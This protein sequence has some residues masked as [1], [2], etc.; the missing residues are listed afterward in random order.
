MRVFDCK[1]RILTGR[2][3]IGRIRELG[4]SRPMI[5]TDPFFSQ[6]GTVQRI[7]RDMGVKQGEIFD[8]VVPDPGLELVAQGVAVAGKFRPDGI[9]ALGGGSAMDCA[10]GVRYFLE[11]RIPLIAIPTTSGSGSEVT[12]FAILTH[13]GVK[14]PLVDE[15]LR[16]EFA[17]LDEELLAAL[18]PSLVADGGFDV[19]THALEAWTGKNANAFTDALAQSAF[20]TVFHSL[21]ASF[22]GDLTVRLSVHE[23]ACMAGL[24][25]TKAGLGLCHALSHALGGQF[26]VPHGRLNAILLPAVIDS[27]ARQD[28]K[29]YGELARRIGLGGISD[30]VALR[31]LKNGLIRLRTAVSLPENLAQGGIPPAALREK[32]DSVIAAALADPCCETN[33]VPVTQETL[34]Q[35][36]YEVMGRG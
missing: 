29:R 26:H 2:G 12:D 31:N 15:S 9:V 36:L 4:F 24:A 8:K 17:I 18:P 7:I 21:T 23:S 20:A 32:M 33:P 28:P 27:N 6:N 19:L 34:R 11:E 25:F 14:H 1:T 16:P 3:T 13:K 22:R 10:K 5:I 30:A 35:V